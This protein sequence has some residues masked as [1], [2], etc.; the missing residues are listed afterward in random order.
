M[1]NNAEWSPAINENVGEVVLVGNFTA[2]HIRFG[3]A[4][5]R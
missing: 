4:T 3:V 1:M 2:P 5:E